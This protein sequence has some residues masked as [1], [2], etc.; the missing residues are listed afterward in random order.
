MREWGR[1]SVMQQR[2]EGSPRF[3]WARLPCLLVVVMKAKWLARSI[4]LQLMLL[5]GIK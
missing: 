4:L 2:K 3:L 5:L 1:Q